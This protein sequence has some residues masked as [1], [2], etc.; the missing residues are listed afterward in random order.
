M[1][2][3]IFTGQLLLLINASAGSLCDFFT[4]LSG[5]NIE[6]K[7]VT[8]FMQQAWHGL[9]LTHMISASLSSHHAASTSSR[10]GVCLSCWILISPS[11]MS[12]TLLLCITACCFLHHP[13]INPEAPEG[14]LLI[15]F[16]FY[17]TAGSDVLADANSNYILLL[18][19]VVSGCPHHRKKKRNITGILGSKPFLYP[20]SELSL[21]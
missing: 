2:T 6:A 13:G 8:E 17:I 5:N 4:F 21:A 11:E 16:S 10:F 14:F 3:F 7:L 15:L 1:V 18:H 19:V 20:Y 12:V 9:S